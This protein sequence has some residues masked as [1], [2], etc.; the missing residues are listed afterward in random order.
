M[1]LWYQK[2]ALV[3]FESPCSTTLIS[4]SNGGKLTFVNRL[5]SNA[6]GIFKETFSNI[7]Y[8][9]GGT[10]QPIFEKMATTLP[11]IIFREG[12]P[13]EEEL[14]EITKNQ[15]H[16]CLV[17]D[18]LMKE[19]N[20]GSRAEKIWMVYKHHLRTTVIYLAHS[21]YQKGPSAKT[22]S[23]NTDYYILFKQN[24]DLLQ[25][26]RFSIQ[27]HSNKSCGFMDAYQKATKGPFSYL[28]VDL[29]IFS[30]PKFLLR[31]QIFPNDD[32]VVY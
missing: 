31:T 22:I 25:V 30:D 3:R 10:W 20:T 8:C 24:C 1:T 15:R 7:V 21:I 9:Y 4:P 17:L 32:T 13:T 11:N 6:L 18:V 5:L 2:E 19:V 29:S 23:L 14:K 27:S 12:L 26:Q 16:T 28:L